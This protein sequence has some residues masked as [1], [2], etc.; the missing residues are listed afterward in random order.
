MAAII[1]LRNEIEAII[2]AMADVDYL[3]A[4]ATEANEKLMRQKITNCLAI[5]T[6]QTE[7]TGTVNNQ[8][9]VSKIIPT[10]IFFVYKNTKLDDK[11]YDTDDLVD[12]AEEKADEFFDKLLQSAVIDDNANFD[13]YTLQRLDSYKRMDA[14]ISGV[15]FTWNAPVSRKQYYCS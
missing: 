10:E 13:D 1:N 15:L 9:Y 14:I 12:Q 5:H 11:L 2:T 6:D 3:R 4:S 7:V 8:L